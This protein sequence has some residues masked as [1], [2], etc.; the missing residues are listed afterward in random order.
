MVLA[1]FAARI[2]RRLILENV[3]AVGLKK[4]LPNIVSLIRIF[5]A[6]SLPLLMW[7]GWKLT[8]SLP[9]LGEFSSVPLVWIVIF[10]LLAVSDKLDGTLARNLNAESGLGAILDVIGDTLLLVV[11]VACVFANFARESL[12]GFQ[13]WVDVFIVIMLVFGKFLVF[14]VTKK[15]FGKGNMLHSFP[16]KAFAVGAYIGVVCWAFMNAIP[17]W[18]LSLLAAIMVYAVID[19]I[20]YVS[21]TA[22]Y[23]VDFRGHGFEKYPLRKKQ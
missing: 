12:S 10:I 4:Y 14:V 13:L 9:S 1:P 3:Q 19:E 16:H 20:V 6:L 23:N 8:I 11:G 21:R 2:K 22:E 18:S 15:Y 5:G 7:E 17:L